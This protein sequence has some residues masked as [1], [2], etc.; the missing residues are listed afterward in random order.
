[1]KTGI[2][3]V[4]VLTLSLSFGGLAGAQAP[5]ATDIK[6]RTEER[7]TRLKIKLDAAATQRLSGKCIAAQAKLKVV[8]AKLRETNDKYLPKYDEFIQ[9]AEKLELSLSEDG[10]KSSELLGQIGEAKTKY[11]TVKTTAAKLQ[12]SLDDASNMDCKADPAGF[13]AAVDDA[14]VEAKLLTDAKQ[15]LTKFARTNI[16]TTLQAIKVN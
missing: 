10:V 2:F 11:D 15:D 3:T 12:T 4:A 9:K 5:A 8:A 13:K 1:M 16:K 7:K 14:R 6:T